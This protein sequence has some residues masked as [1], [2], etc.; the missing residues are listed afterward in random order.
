MGKFYHPR[1]E[2][3]SNTRGGFVPVLEL[4]AREGEDAGKRFTIDG[5]EVLVGRK[6]A[7]SE[8]GRGVLLRDATVS[9]RQ[10]LIRR[11][12][13]FFVLH[14]I[15]GTTNPT[16]IDGEAFESSR[17][18]VGTMIRMGGVLLEVCERSGVA[19]SG[20]TQLLL[21]QAGDERWKQREF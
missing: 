8:Q 17:L 9:S 16:L 18:R 10:A 15:E 20:L 6:L 14:S 4:L 13:E 3:S 7:E 11:D 5:D 21:G 2:Q 19:I 1:I 12:G